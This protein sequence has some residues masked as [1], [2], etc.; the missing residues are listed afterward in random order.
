MLKE[1]PKIPKWF[2]LAGR[3]AMRSQL[4]H[5]VVQHRRY[6]LVVR[7]AVLPADAGPVPPVPADP[8]VA[9][10]PVPGQTRPHP[11]AAEH[12]GIHVT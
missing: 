5:L 6:H 10:T 7:P 9:A 1:I 11:R 2:H 12:A 3:T 4:G 8:P